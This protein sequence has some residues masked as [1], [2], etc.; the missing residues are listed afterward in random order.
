MRE[1]SGRPTGGPGSRIRRTAS[2][3]SQWVGA[4]EVGV[5]V[6]TTASVSRAR[7]R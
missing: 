1:G 6:M 5:E 4:S 7:V 3:P 2:A